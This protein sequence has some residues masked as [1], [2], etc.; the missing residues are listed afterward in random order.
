MHPA[1]AV[2]HRIGHYSSQ[3][4]T[5]T[6]TTTT[7]TSP[8]AATTTIA[9]SLSDLNTISSI[10]TAISPA[11]NGHGG[12]TTVS[13][14]TT[15]SAPAI[16]TNTPATTNNG[17]AAPPLQFALVTPVAVTT[18]PPPTALPAQPPVL[19]L[20][21][22]MMILARA[23]RLSTA[24]QQTLA[25][26]DAS[27][28]EDFCCM[29]DADFSSMVV[30][31]TRLGKPIPPLQQRKIRILHYWCLDIVRE[32]SQEQADAKEAQ[33]QAEVKTRQ[34]AQAEAE[35]PDH[36]G[37]E[38]AGPRPSL[39]RQDSNRPLTQQGQQQQQKQMKNQVTPERFG[40]LPHVDN[41]GDDTGNLIMPSFWDRALDPMG[42]LKEATR[43]R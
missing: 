18:T 35:Q 10:P 39:H 13:V 42:T 8:T 5:T 33:R 27:T 3:P 36:Y 34:L 9:A 40:K 31:D 20:G 2:A 4:K 15:N 28:L 22:D 23:M 12:G 26:Y 16:D 32:Y 24:T 7:T 29:T 6:T 30:T 14:S 17:A 1:F 38:V 41:D 19:K 11:H 37:V 21:E 43:M 25:T